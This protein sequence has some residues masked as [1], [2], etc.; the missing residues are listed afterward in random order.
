MALNFADLFEHG[1]DAFAERTALVCGDRQVTYRRAGGARQPARAPPG[2]ARRVAP[3]DHVGL[4]A[5]NSSSA[6]ETLIAAFKVRAVPV[7]INYRYVEDEL[8]YLLH[9]RRPGGAGL[10]PGVRAAGGRH[11]GGMPRCAAAW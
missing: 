2:R 6:A 4:Y 5:R 10:R 1:A 11:G 3:G 8:R 9:R 7:N